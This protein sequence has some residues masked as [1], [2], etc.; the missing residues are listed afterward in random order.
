MKPAGFNPWFQF[1]QEQCLF[2][3]QGQKGMAK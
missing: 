3:H 2:C 1:T